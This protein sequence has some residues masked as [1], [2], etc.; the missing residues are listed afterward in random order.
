MPSTECHGG[1]KVNIKGATR[2]TTW[3]RGKGI[4]VWTKRVAF[5]LKSD[6]T[7]GGGEGGL[8]VEGRGQGVEKVD[9]PH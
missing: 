6:G 3:K 4:R 9:L 7:R 8:E 2:V 5:S 1:G